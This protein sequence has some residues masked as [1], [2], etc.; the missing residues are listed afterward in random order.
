M[1]L[2]LRV[3]GHHKLLFD[4]GT[5]DVSKDV[6]AE[7]RTII[8][9]LEIAD[10]KTNVEGS[11][12]CVAMAQAAHWNGY[13]PRCSCTM[14][15]ARSRTSAKNLFDLFMAPFSQELEP[16]SNPGR[17]S[18]LAPGIVSRR[19]Y[20]LVSA[21]SSAAWLL[22]TSRVQVTRAGMPASDIILAMLL[23][24]QSLFSNPRTRRFNE[25]RILGNH[26]P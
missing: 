16:P 14:R 26:I 15:A 7:F 10:T 6:T 5:P 9:T 21:R 3:V 11:Y 23:A 2:R 1:R 8:K 20:W 13:S 17:F 18:R 12:H 4:A 25:Q 24:R 22:I 19:S